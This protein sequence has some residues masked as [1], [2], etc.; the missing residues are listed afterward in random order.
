MKKLVAMFITLAAATAFADSTYPYYPDVE[1]RFCDYKEVTPL[2]A[3]KAAMLT[4]PQSDPP[5]VICE[6][7]VLKR[8]CGM[9]VCYQISY[10]NGKNMKRARK[11]N[12]LIR[13]VNTG[14]NL[15]AREVSD[16]LAEFRKEGFYDECETGCVDGQ[17]FLFSDA[18]PGGK[19]IP[20]AFT[21]FDPCYEKASH[22]A[23]T[24]QLYFT[25]FVG[26]S[27]TFLQH[28]KFETETGEEIIITT[29]TQPFPSAA[30]ISRLAIENREKKLRIFLNDPVTYDMEV[31]NR[32]LIKWAEIEAGVSDEMAQGEFLEVLPRE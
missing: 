15:L 20:S 22:E 1:E 7:L 24:D 13:R 27:R 16:T 14:E 11:F 32:N 21:G 6:P 25:G 31:I 19:G 4:G 30:K 26:V 17:T 9:P 3:V 12:D 29:D 5:Y 18:G 10:Y 23:G 8:L 28:F 2:M